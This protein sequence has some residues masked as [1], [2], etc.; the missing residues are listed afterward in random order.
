M[1]NIFTKRLSVLAAVFLL[2]ASAF[3]Y[4]AGVE[5]KYKGSATLEGLGIVPVTA[6]LKGSD[7]KLSGVINSDQGDAQI[8]DGNFK[9]GKITLQITVGDTGATINGT[10]DEQGKIAGSVTGDQINGTIE[11][12]RVKETPAVR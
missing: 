6:E 11:M 9:D 2:A 1:K 4:F 5:G 7:D 12:S 3:A 8:L 10:V